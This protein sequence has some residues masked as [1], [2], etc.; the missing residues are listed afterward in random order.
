MRAAVAFAAAIASSRIRR[1]SFF[2]I[3]CF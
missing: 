1:I 3:F 2:I